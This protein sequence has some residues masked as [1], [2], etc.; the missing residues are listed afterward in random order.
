MTAAGRVR[1]G[2]RRARRTG[3]SGAHHHRRARARRTR[4]DHPDDRLAVARGCVQRGHGVHGVLRVDGAQAVN[5][6]M[7]RDGGET[8]R[9]TIERIADLAG[10]RTWEVSEMFWSHGVP[11]PADHIVV[12]PKAW[13]DSIAEEQAQK[14]WIETRDL[15]VVSVESSG[16]GSGM[17]VLILLLVL[18]A[19]AFGGFFLFTLKVAIIVAIVLLLV[20]FFGSTRFRARP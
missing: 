1:T 10:M 9:V 19:L 4:R 18:L 17:L 16:Y 3:L 20:G 11:V 5:E 6:W 14:A 15:R 7:V 12:V 13:I 8:A 2:T